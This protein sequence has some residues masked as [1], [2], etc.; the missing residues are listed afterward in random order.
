MSQNRTVL[1]HHYLQNELSA[2]GSTILPNV[3]IDITEVE[4]QW[5][6]F[7]NEIEVLSPVRLGY[8]RA[9][10]IGSKTIKTCHMSLRNSE[11]RY[12]STHRGTN[13]TKKFLVLI[14]FVILKR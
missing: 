2:Y 9:F 7:S 13:Q 3:V 8:W 11:Y 5:K 14:T 1:I 6:Y 10:G 4:I 12:C